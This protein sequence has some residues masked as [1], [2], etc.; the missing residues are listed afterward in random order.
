MRVRRRAAAW[1]GRGRS[2]TLGRYREA[3]RL[4]RSCSPAAAFSRTRSAMST[5]T[6]RAARPARSASLP[7]RSWLDSTHSSAKASSSSNPRSREPVQHPVRPR[8]ASSPSE[9]VLQFLLRVGPASEDRPGPRH[10]LPVRLIRR[11]GRIGDRG[12]VE[13]RLLRHERYAS[14]RVLLRFGFGDCFRSDVD[15]IVVIRPEE[16]ELLLDLQF[17]LSGDV[18][19]LGEERLRV[20]ASLTELVLSVDEPG[21]R[22]PARCRDRWPRRGDCPPSRCPRRTGCRTRP[23]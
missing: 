19:V 13:E 17:D 7:L 5:S 18:G 12:R 4:A 2:I 16:A 3:I 14:L 1:A 15:L 23:S 20:L 6:P 11:G 22:L 8:R 9:L 10:R 21:P